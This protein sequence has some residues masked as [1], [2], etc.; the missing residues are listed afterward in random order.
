MGALGAYTS[1]PGLE[2]GA[3][4]GSLPA[5]GGIPGLG[6]YGDGVPGFIAAL[7][8]SPNP[9]P[10]NVSFLYTVPSPRDSLH[11]SSAKVSPGR[12]LLL[13]LRR[14]DEKAF[15]KAKQLQV[16]LGT[17]RLPPGGCQSPFTWGVAA[18]GRG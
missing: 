13:R 10:H 15:R 18:A 1:L 5:E 2:R 14:A 12:L 3:A 6:C 11:A 16:A 8:V 7:R 9:P 4:W 17:L